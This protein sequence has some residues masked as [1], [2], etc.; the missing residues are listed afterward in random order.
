MNL[1]ESLVMMASGGPHATVKLEVEAGGAG[2]GRKPGFGTKE[3]SSV[4]SLLRLSKAN[5]KN[6]KDEEDS[7]MKRMYHSDAKDHEKLAKH[8]SNGDYKKASN[9]LSR[10]DTSPAEDALEHISEGALRKM[11]MGHEND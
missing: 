10:M 5:H 3:K 7:G 11:G 4:N 6:A 9:H 8:L 1:T 2:S